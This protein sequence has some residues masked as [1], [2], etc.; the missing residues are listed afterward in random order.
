VGKIKGIMDSDSGKVAYVGDGRNDSPT[1]AVSDVGLAMGGLGSDVAIESADV[2]VL[3]DN[4]LKI[5][6][7]LRHSRKIMRIV[8]ENIIF[9]LSV[10][11]LVMAISAFYIMPM[12]IAMFADIGVMLLPVLNSIRC[13]KVKAQST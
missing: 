9:S 3:D 7:A 8:K 5:S 12:G 2:V 1:L 11:F 13:G 4:L 6:Y 10:K